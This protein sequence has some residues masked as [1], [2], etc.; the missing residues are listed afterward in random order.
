MRI[1][2]ASEIGSFLYC[3]RS[4]WYQ[5]KGYDSENTAQ[6]AGGTELHQD[7]SQAIAA[8]GCLRTVAVGF[9]LAAFVLLVLHFTNQIL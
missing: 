5:R 8:T 1:I 3:N 2:K 6:L 7:H 9:L 4:W